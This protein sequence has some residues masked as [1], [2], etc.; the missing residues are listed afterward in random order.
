MK[1]N[2]AKLK[3]LSSPPVKISM[4]PVCTEIAVLVKNEEKNW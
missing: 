2:R 4:I 3:R 1:L